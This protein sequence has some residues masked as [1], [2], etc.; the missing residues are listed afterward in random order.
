MKNYKISKK[1]IYRIIFIIAFIVFVFSGYKLFTI[2]KAN[3]E[4]NS[5]KERIT[6]ISDIPKNIKKDTKFKVNFKKLKAINNDIVAWIVIPDTDISYPVVQGADNDFYLNHTFEK[7]ENYAGAIF[8][9]YAASPNYSDL[10]TFMYGHNI[11]H[12]TMFSD[13][14]KF[15]DKA[16]F[17]AHPYLYLFTPEKKYR[18][19]IM[20]MYST[21]ASSD[22]YIN[23]YTSWDGFSHYVD[24]IKSK[25]MY[26]R[27]V[28]FQE[29]DRMITLS[30][31]S[32]E[33]GGV[34]SD[35]RYLLHA[36]L[37]EWDKTK[38]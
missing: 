29:G 24:L 36:K 35:A 25:A 17:E 19:D 7:R 5:E 33:R 10:N 8:N 21:D 4:E 12:G 2:Y 1:I 26:P 27:E 16:F 9:D 37:V 34:A 11:K 31:C 30:T 13:I 32:Y 22:S 23:G 28:P 14:Q 15:K 6:S 20:S 3:W 18:C 38:K